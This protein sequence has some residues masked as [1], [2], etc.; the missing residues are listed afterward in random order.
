MWY[1]I[2]EFLQLF[3]LL[4]ILHT[5]CRYSHIF[6]IILLHKRPT[7]IPCCSA[8]GPRL[9]GYM[10]NLRCANSKPANMNVKKDLQAHFLPSTTI[11]PASPANYR[12]APRIQR[13]VV[14]GCTESALARCVHSRIFGTMPTGLQ[15]QELLPLCDFPFSSSSWRA[16]PPYLQCIASIGN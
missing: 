16:F 2:E 4:V 5:V 1:R 14:F 9:N 11:P 13:V 6:V 3:L 15:N 12:P 10:N 8:S 7:F